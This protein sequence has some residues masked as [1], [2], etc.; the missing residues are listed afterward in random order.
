M[1]ITIVQT[2]WVVEKSNIAIKER[3][4]IDNKFKQMAFAN[5]GLLVTRPINK[6]RAGYERH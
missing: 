2:T 1:R 4:I 5:S 3:L 6:D